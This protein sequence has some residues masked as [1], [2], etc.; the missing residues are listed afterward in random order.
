MKAFL[1]FL[2]GAAFVG[3]LLAG[4]P[5]L[6]AVAG[7]L[8][9]F[10]LFLRWMTT[11]GLAGVTCRRAVKPWASEDQSLLV[12]IEVANKGRLPAFALTI[13]DQ[14]GPDRDAAKSAKVDGILRPGARTTVAYPAA[15]TRKRGV[16][17]VGPL[18]AAASDPLGL[19]TFRKTIPSTATVTVTPKLFPIDRMP[20]E[21]RSRWDTL[22]QRTT[23]KAGSSLNFFG[24]REYRRG[25]NIRFIHW[26]STARSGKW[27]VKEFESD[28]SSEVTILLDL[29]YFTLKGSGRETT[30]DYA[31]R[32]AGA[33]A[34]YAVGRSSLVQLLAQ[35]K[36]R[37]QIPLGGGSFHLMTIL[38]ELAKLSASGETPLEDVL[39][40][41]V[42]ILNGGS[43]LVIIFNSVRLD[44]VKYVN[45][46]TILRAKGV[47]ILAVLIDD[48]TFLDLWEGADRK[49]VDATFIPDILKLLMAQGVTAYLVRRGDELP[50]VFLKPFIP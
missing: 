42:P 43:T 40:Q 22:G 32:I 37:V 11:R 45:A 44:L 12:E 33:I 13:E 20:L 1:W 18:V 50:Q 26:P 31:C 16:F 30:L 15:C 7:A 49:K 34:R 10:V 28:L 46:I 35:G 14:Y 48:N 9:A 47:Q 27:I 17:T 21:G 8:A 39:L 2:G 25:D 29:H 36:E 6:L 3:G 41:A 38:D 24:T 23:L 5:S 4:L 19:F